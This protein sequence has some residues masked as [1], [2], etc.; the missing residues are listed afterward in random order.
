ME[1]G[2]DKTSF[3]C[4]DILCC[5]SSV[6]EPRLSRFQCYKIRYYGRIDSLENIQLVAG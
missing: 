2:A 5:S 1:S 6:V 3:F 4:L